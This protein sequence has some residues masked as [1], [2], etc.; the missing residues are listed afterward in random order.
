MLGFGAFASTPFFNP[1][2]TN[3]PLGAR[4][5]TEHR[6]TRHGTSVH[7]HYSSADFPRMYSLNRQRRRARR[8]GRAAAEQP[9]RA[10][11]A[12]AAWR[13]EQAR[14]TGRPTAPGGA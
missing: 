13:A 8:D 11:A 4:D 5:E 6:K 9:A 1:Q 2:R 3:C 12:I 14:Q 7:H 10:M